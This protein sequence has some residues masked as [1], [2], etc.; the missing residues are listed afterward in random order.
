MMQSYFLIIIRKFTWS[1]GK[2]VGLIKYCYSVVE[3]LFQALSSQWRPAKEKANKN[4]GCAWLS[5]KRL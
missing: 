2:I 1:K 5:K 4:G 3:G